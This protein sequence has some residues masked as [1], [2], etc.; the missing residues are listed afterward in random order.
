VNLHDVCER[1]KAR[2]REEARSVG[3]T[4][5]FS[6]ERG[7]PIRVYRGCSRYSFEGGILV[8]EAARLVD[9][10]SG[11]GIAIAI[12]SAHIA[13][14]VLV[15]L[16]EQG[17]LGPRAL[18]AYDQA[19]LKRFRLELDVTDLVVSAVRQ[20]ALQKLWL[21]S[22]RWMSTTASRDPEYASQVGGIFAGLIPNWRAFSPEILLKPLAHLPAF[23]L[24]E[25]GPLDR[26][27]PAR[28]LRLGEAYVAWQGELARAWQDDPAALK[29]WAKELAEKQRRVVSELTRAAATA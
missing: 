21:W 2:L 26:N 17:D 1:L 12:E 8:G 19:I 25:L 23:C 16:F 28:M 11:E 5:S 15:S 10:I 4:V 6:E 7:F 24:E 3:A 22:F 18:E 20:R 14:R 29:S 13:G 9:P 27:L